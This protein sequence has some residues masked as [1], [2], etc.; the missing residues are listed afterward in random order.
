M[1]AGQLCNACC[2]GWMRATDCCL[3]H[4]D[5]TTQQHMPDAATTRTAPAQAIAP[6][7]SGGVVCLVKGDVWVFWLEWWD[8]GT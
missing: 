4:S 3:L 6:K 1:G 5:A 7:P 8:W 2:A